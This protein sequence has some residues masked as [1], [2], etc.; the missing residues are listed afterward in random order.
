MEFYKCLNNMNVVFGVSLRILGYR[1]LFITLCDVAGAIIIPKKSD[2]HHFFY[3]CNGK[4][5]MLD[6]AR[7][8]KLA[9]NF[10]H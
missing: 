7:K 10:F 4:L 6:V 2:S 5:K 9:T 3:C 1:Y 8:K